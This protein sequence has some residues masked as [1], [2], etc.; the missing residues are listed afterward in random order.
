[1]Y[2][3]LIVGA[4]P[5]GSYIADKL[6]A[7]GHKV[8]VFEK[9]EKVGEAVCCTGIVGKEC[10]DLVPV[11]GNVILREENSAKFFAPSGKFLHL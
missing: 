2:D 3:T 10:L 4:G 7:S 11:D 1:M 8:I 5:T 6:A 9:H